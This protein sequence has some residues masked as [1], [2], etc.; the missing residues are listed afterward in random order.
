[1]ARDDPPKLMR[2]QGVEVASPLCLA[3][4]SLL[5]VLI[6]PVQ[7]SAHVAEKTSRRA[8]SHVPWRLGMRDARA[9]AG[10]P[11]GSMQE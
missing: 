5:V 4:G 8:F 6:P 2:A 7:V 11:S 10:L 3:S 9:H 1:M